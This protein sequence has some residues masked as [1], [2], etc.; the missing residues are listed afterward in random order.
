MKARVVHRAAGLLAL[1]VIATAIAALG[2]ARAPTPTNH[3]D[4]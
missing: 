1:V 3:G 2:D 4:R